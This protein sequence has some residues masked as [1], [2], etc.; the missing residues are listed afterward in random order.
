[1]QRTAWHPGGAP[2]ADGSRS[3][4]HPWRC[5]NKRKRSKERDRV[6]EAYLGDT[7]GAPLAPMRT[8]R[9][10]YPTVDWL[11]SLNHKIVAVVGVVFYS[12][13]GI[14]LLVSL[15]MAAKPA[16]AHGDAAWIEAGKYTN[17]AGQL[18]CGERDCGVFH[19]GKITTTP[20]GYRID[21]TF[22]IHNSLMRTTTDVEVHELIPYS[23]ATPS[24]DG[25]FWRCA[26][27][28]ERKCFFAPPPG[29]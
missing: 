23:E 20:A 19:D 13:L 9:A 4:Y 27:G 7:V 6:V 1:M 18:C 14:A 5:A 24:P 2:N 28:G 3:Q 16:R 12:L 22:R 8:Y 11:K 15:F 21:G 26:W 10:Q 17:A 29:S 25:R